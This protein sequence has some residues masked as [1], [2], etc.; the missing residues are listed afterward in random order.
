MNWQERERERFR[1]GT[2]A[3]MPIVLDYPEEHYVHLS[4]TATEIDYVAYTP[5]S[6]YGEANRQVR[7][8]FGR[9]LKKAF[10]DM[11]DAEI[12]AHVT[13]LKSALAAQV[14]PPALHIVKDIG[15]IND[16]FETPMKACGS[17]ALS[18]MYDK[19][20]GDY[21]RPYHVYADSPDVG[22]AYV[23]AGGKIIARSVVSTKDKTWVRAYAIVEGGND[24]HCGT[25]RSLLDAAG[26]S[27]GELTGNRLTKLETEDVMLPYID[28]GGREVCDIGQYWLVV[29]DGQ[30]EYEA[31]CVDGTA[32]DLR[33]HC[34]HCEELEDDCHCS[35]CECCGG[36][37]TD[38]CENC[39]MCEECDSCRSHNVCGCRRCYRCDEIINPRSRYTN[40]CCCGRCECCHELLR[41]C[42][43]EEEEEDAPEDAPIPLVA[44]PADPADP[45]TRLEARAKLNRI[46]SYLRQTYGFLYLGPEY[47]LLRD[48]YTRTQ[49]EE[50]TA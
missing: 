40:S 43:C 44:D 7:L 34:R 45:V 11:T 50:V 37:S 21:I 3:N 42:E 10:P 4:V 13:S 39:Y 19:F 8:K 9:Y 32:K 35:V 36:R 25:L 48:A 47:E 1:D 30:G 31:N 49:E 6:A 28:T 26:Y 14:A 18:C 2:Y 15:S 22:V 23:T 41:D 33:E 20:D 27:K 29:P 12:Q 5:G 17:S 38:G 46:W 16:V 24:T